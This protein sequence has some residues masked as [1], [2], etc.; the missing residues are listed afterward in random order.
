MSVETKVDNM[1]AIM[2]ALHSLTGRDVLVGIPSERSERLDKGEPIDNATLGYIHEFGAPRANIP[3]RPF[4]FPGVED[5]RPEVLER[6]AK[7]TEAAL[8]GKDGEVERQLHTAGLIA[9]NKVRARINEGIAPELSEST[10][11]A[12]QARGRTGTKP[13]ID[14]G[15][16]RNSITYVIRKK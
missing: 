14:T 13:L 7:A 6:F 12:R 3:A 11:K 5:A 1:A 9:Q 16:L 2:R 15:Q 10:I 8:Q 4:L